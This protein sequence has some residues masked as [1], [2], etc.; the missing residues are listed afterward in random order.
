MNQKLPK[1]LMIG[2]IYD[3]LNHTKLIRGMNLLGFDSDRYGLNISRVLFYVMDLNTEDR[4]LDK[5][6]DDY[7][8]RTARVEEFAGN[9]SES[10]DILAG[11]IYNWLLKERK[12]YSKRLLKNV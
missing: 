7:C 10:L 5:I 8:E 9:D 1:K 2:L 6:T 4:R 11:D 3:D 12:K